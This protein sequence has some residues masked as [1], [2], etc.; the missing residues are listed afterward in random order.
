MAIP[1]P[2]IDPV[3]LAIGPLEIRWYAL[4]YIAGFL[5]G[6]RYGLWMVGLDKTK[7]PNKD[8]V[9]DL[10]SWSVLGVILGGRIGYVLFYQ[11]EVYLESPLE[12]F[13]V[14]NGGMSFH[15]GVLGVILTL[16]IFARAKGIS[17]LRLTDVFCC[18]CPIGIGLGR[19]ANFIN[20][21]LFGKVTDVSWGMV[22]PQGGP[23][24]R[25]PSQIYEAGLEGLL[26]FIVLF[27][28]V[29]HEPVRR[30]PGL[31]SGFFL[32]GYG[33]SRIF[34]E[35]FREP[36]LQIGYVVNIYTM[37]QIL[38]LPMVLL[39]VGLIV[40]VRWKDCWFGKRAA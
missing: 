22:F 33:L 28:L 27:A 13:K 10:I 1:Y 38:S 3:A 21:E 15:G 37:G 16:V 34:V 30:Q 26:L 36:D 4:A 24:P 19:L 20:G 12:I 6:W 35:I 5:L 8:D 2:E 40:F 11:P 32:I 14:W 18:A 39:G 31:L 25:H 29:R 17:F 7:R 9:D 23:L